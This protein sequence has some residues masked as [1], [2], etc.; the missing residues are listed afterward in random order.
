MRKIKFRAWDKEN[1]MY[2]VQ[3]L[4][5]DK[6]GNLSMPYHTEEMGVYLMQFTNLKDKNGKDVYEGDIVRRYWDGDKPEDR[7]IVFTAG[8][9]MW[10][11]DKFATGI[12]SSWAEI[13][14]NMYEN[15]DLLTNKE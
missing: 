8:A 3:N 10:G 1:G 5:F 15:S 13:I 14:G 6:E 4:Y 11:K 7:E 2:V 9:F 12:N